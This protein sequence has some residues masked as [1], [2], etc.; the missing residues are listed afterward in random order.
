MLPLPWL[1]TGPAWLRIRHPYQGRGGKKRPPLRLERL[2]R[3]DL[4]AATLQ[5][6][7]L[8]TYSL[9]PSDAAGGAS[10][11]QTSDDGRFT[12]YTSNAPNLIS[13][14]INVRP[15]NNVFLS[16]RDTQTTT[17]ISHNAA[18]PLQTGNALSEAARIS[19][20]GQFI[21]YTSQATDLVPQQ[22]GSGQFNNV[23]LYNRTTGMTTLVSHD[24]SSP[25]LSGEGDSTTTYTTGFG[26]TNT[27]GRYLIFDSTAPDLLLAM[28][29]GP[30]H[31]NLFMYDTF[32]GTTSL[33]SHDVNSTT[34]G[35]MTIRWARQTS[36]GMAT[37]SPTPLSLPTSCLPNAMTNPVMFSF[38]IAQHK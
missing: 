21:V 29:A 26:S 35:G 2:E 9:A 12:V 1:R 24:A 17:L 32:L 7:P 18:N 28:Q 25:T 10:Q 13:G 5:S 22:S 36:A 37:S 15:E 30:T 14:Q 31:Q 23:F 3:R 4:F 11:T 6:I 34:T 38:T 8:P 16:D 33:V 27:M 20:D 19:G